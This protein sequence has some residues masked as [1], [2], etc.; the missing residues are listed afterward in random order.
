[1][2]DDRD[3]TRVL[4]ILG[5]GETSPAMVTPHQQLFARLAPGTTAVVLD[6][7]YGFQENADELSQRTIEYFRQSVGR[8]VEAVSFR[9]APVTDPTTHATEM[10]RL[11]SA[12]WIFAGPGS[13][14]YALRTWTGSAVPDALHAVLRDGGAVVF[15]SAAA[16]T[17]GMFTVPVYEI[18]K[19]GETP[20]WLDGLDVFGRATGLKAA[21]VPH[22]N[23]AEGGTHDTRFCYLGERR[24]RMLEDLLPDDAFVLGIDE[25]TGIVIDLETGKADVVGRGSVTVRVRGREWS[26]TTGATT[27]LTEI[28]EHTHVDVRP[29]AAP[30]PIPATTQIAALEHALEQRDVRTALALTAELDRA[31]STDTER[32]IA[33]TYL[34]RCIAALNNSVDMTTAATPYIQL[35]LAERTRARNEKRWSDSD[36]IRDGLSAIGVEVRDGP[37]GVTWT[38]TP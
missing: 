4:M 26:L 36:A 1:M 5:S 3:M 23:N 32:Q 19:V 22:W 9:S 12:G 28:A 16:L 6:S 37:T 38:L 27:T 31:A 15:A 14:S 17:L 29:T 21:I 24:L 34:A 35:L 20:R 10:A 30:A 33:G 25:H 2:S 7:P 8:D 11:R 18:Y 13:P